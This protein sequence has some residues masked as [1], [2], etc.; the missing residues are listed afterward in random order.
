MTPVFPVTMLVKVLLV[1]RLENWRK[2]AQV[3][4]NHKG[5]EE[6]VVSASWMETQE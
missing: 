5:V 6:E 1:A 2:A 3:L 4:E